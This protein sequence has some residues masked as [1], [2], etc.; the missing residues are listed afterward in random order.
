MEQIP[1]RN[2]SAQDPQREIRIDSRLVAALESLV[3]SFQTQRR[4]RYVMIGVVILAYIAIF[5]A[6]PGTS[7]RADAAFV[8]GRPYD[9]VVDTGRLVDRHE[10]YRLMPS[11]DIPSAEVLGDIERFKAWAAEQAKKRQHGTFAVIPV[12]GV[13]AHQPVQDSML[14]PARDPVED[15]LDQLEIAFRDGVDA[16]ILDIASPGG[17]VSACEEIYRAVQKLKLRN[18]AVVAYARNV[19]ASGGYYIAAPADAIVGTPASW[20]GSIGVILQLINYEELAGKIGVRIETLK[21]ADMKDVGSSWRRMTP[22]E[23]SMLQRLVTSSFT[24]FVEAVSSGRNMT[25]AETRK[26]ATGAVFGSNDAKD[27]GLIDHIGDF[28]TATDAA[29]L[30]TGVTSPA[31]VRYERKRASF[32]DLFAATLE[33]FQGPV[34]TLS[35]QI[36]PSYAEGPRLLYQWIP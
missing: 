21:S 15:I 20:I 32:T 17:E 10:P 25:G 12:Y 28:G 7:P 26:V 9:K 23:R 27:L 18:I 6:M 5:V 29:R 22:E 36:M 8:N 14:G 35:T 1:E 4:I 16:V 13:I 11:V 31:I 19:M 34:V 30:K 3:K 33:R 24:R 2:D